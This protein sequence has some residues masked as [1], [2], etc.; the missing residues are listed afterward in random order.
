MEII[1]SRD[2]QRHA[3][4][5]LDFGEILKLLTHQC[6]TPLGRSLALQL[7]PSY[8]PEEVWKLLNLSQEAVDLL[9]LSPVPSMEA[10][11]DLRQTFILA[12]KGSTLQGDQLIKIGHALSAMR[13]VK[14][15]LYAKREQSPEIW[16]LGQPLPDLKTTESRILESIE[17]GGEVKDTASFELARLRKNRIRHTQKIVDRVQ[18][19]V[20]GKLREYLS[21][22]LYTV[23][24]G[25]YVV[26]L[27]I[28]HRGKIRGIVHDISA[29]GQTLYVE[30]EDILRL[31]NELREIEAAEKEE[32]FRVL[33]ELS[34]L[35]GRD[36]QEAIHGIEVSGQLDLIFAK[37]RL[38]HIM[39]AKS[40]I[41]EKNF[42]VSITHGRHPLIDPKKVVPLNIEV[43]KTCDT[44]MLTG[45]NTGGKTVAMKTIGL[46]VLMAQ[47]GM[48]L[49]AE[50]VR[51][52]CFNQIWADIGD[53]QSLQ[54][55]LST[56][57]GHI[58]NIADALRNVKEG[59]LVLLDEI[60]AGTDPS[61]GAALAKAILLRLQNAGAK[62]I[63]ST[64]YGE[65]KLFAYNTDGFENAAM[66][67]DLK[68]LQP[69]YHLLRNAAGA[70]HG[71]KIAERYGIPKDVVEEARSYL[72]SGEQDI[73]RVLESLEQSQ[74]LARRA[75][76]EADRLTARLR[77]VEKET[78][79]KLIQADEARRSARA[80]ANEAIQTLLRELRLEADDVFKSLKDRSNAKDIDVA[81]KKLKQIQE[82]GEEE[83]LLFSD[84]IS[85][86]SSKI[87]IKTG[88][89]VNIVGYPQKGTVLSIKNNEI[90]IVQVGVIKISVPL[91][92]LQPMDANSIV[93]KLSISK[94]SRL[95]LQ[96]TTQISPEVHIR[97]MRVE[98]AQEVIEKFLD[99]ATLAGIASVRIVHGKGGGILRNLVRAYLSKHPN[100]KNYRDGAPFEGGTGVTIAELR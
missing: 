96:K 56:F 15:Y 27:K 59:A 34:K 23:R 53:E 89:I 4:E 3:Y 8:N 80:K 47:S 57:S 61:E 100:I 29:S 36:A 75:Q 55:S 82:H 7:L 31:G 41:P 94:K 43:G 71:L 98:E 90:A 81:R 76:S 66:E 87:P 16:K 50:E 44:L 67:F 78:E 11:L 39:H 74:R 91:S 46:F 37:A 14:Y 9:S 33:G 69:T 20:S 17:E 68:T 73:S 84:P 58:R 25:R 13:S 64:H 35:V 62:V 38:A 40:P 72:T 79:Q 77:A 5:I 51:L 10:I 70:S 42:T 63:A 26:P 60:G 83:S 52:G 92:N 93:S 95:V 1:L 12:L 32:I 99:D 18:L 21:D 28:E 24:D 88:M 19:Y 86:S 48:M 65:L 30:P 54:Q 22:P 85:Q 49:P 6:Q 97:N 45:P 2:N